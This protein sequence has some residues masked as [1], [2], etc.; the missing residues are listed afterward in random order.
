MEISP[1]VPCSFFAGR[2]PRTGFTLIELLV[3]IAI[4]AIL[5]GLLVPAVQKV[6]EA[7]A[8]TQCRNNLKQ[9]GLAVMT[10]Y[11][12]YKKFPAGHECRAADGRGKTDGTSA[13]PYYFSNWAIQILPYLEQEPLFK[14]YNNSVP[15]D[16]PAN[17]GVRQTY[18][19]IYSCPSDPNINQLITPG[20]TFGKGKNGP[21]M[22][23]SY[24]G[25]AGINDAAPP[26]TPTSSP[27][28]WGGYP[29]EMTDLMGWGPGLATRG[30]L[31][32]VDD[33]NNLK[34]EKIQNIV[35]GTSNTLLV[36]ERATRTTVN[37]GTFW[38]NS[39]NLY[40]LSSGGIQSA[41]LL[42]DYNACTGLVV[43]DAYPCKYGWGSFHNG[44]IN[45]VCCDGHV[46]TISSGIDMSV[47]QALCTIAGNEVIPIEF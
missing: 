30:V 25:V 24:R 31:H 10:Y 1:M 17:M 13:S 6:R 46:V 5:I 8:N 36:G 26:P 38:A 37:R 20:S 33:W 44:G 41:S 29:N 4:I 19:A 12:S 7:A 2:R 23:G 18:L 32:G 35:D 14:M 11:D 22:T 15:N 3:V 34:N 16:D 40:S 47:F 42:N 45:F 28:D 27:P 39:F 9:I 43:G 21:Y